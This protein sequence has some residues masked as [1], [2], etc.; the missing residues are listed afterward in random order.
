MK[1]LLIALT[2]LSG[3]AYANTCDSL[4][5]ADGAFY[6]SSQYIRENLGAPNWADQ[7]DELENNQYIQAC[8]AEARAWEKWYKCDQQLKVVKSFQCEVSPIHSSEE[9][10]DSV[11]FDILKNQAMRLRHTYAGFDFVYED[12]FQNG[13][14]YSE[15]K[16]SK[17]QITFA[18]DGEHSGQLASFDGGKTYQGKAVIAEDSTVYLECK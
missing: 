10:V 17:S 14:A 13:K 11:S 15:V 1:T 2:I 3:Q 9:V 12:E 8:H 16:F 5:P 6:F 18:H 4:R 7:C